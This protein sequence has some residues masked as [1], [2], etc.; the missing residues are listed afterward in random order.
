M[1]FFICGIVTYYIL[2]FKTDNNKKLPEGH[3]DALQL[4]FCVGESRVVWVKVDVTK[5]TKR[6]LRNLGA[7]LPCNYAAA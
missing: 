6:R 5:E 1:P 4:S 3:S 2:D 7:Y